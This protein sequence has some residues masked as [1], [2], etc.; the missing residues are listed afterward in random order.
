[1]TWQ[2]VTL[3]VDSHPKA[4]RETLTA[5]NKRPI[6]LAFDHGGSAKQIEVLENAE[7]A[8]RTSNGMFAW[9]FG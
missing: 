1:M 3:L 4:C 7:D 6:D 8:A 5:T 9:L 2:V